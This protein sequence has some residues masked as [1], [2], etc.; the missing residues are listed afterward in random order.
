MS[1]LRVVLLLVGA[2]IITALIIWEKR[3]QRSPNAFRNAATQ[4]D[5]ADESV[6]ATRNRIEPRL[7]SPLPADPEPVAETEP[8]PVSSVPTAR[9]AAPESE[10][11]SQAWKQLDLEEEAMRLAEK[12]TDADTG[13]VTAPAQES[14]PQAAPPTELQATAAP[15]PAAEPQDAGH[16][17]MPEELVI[18]YIVAS[19]GR[20]IKGPEIQQAMKEAGLQFG[21]MNLFHYPV[22]SPEGQT[23]NLF[24]VADIREPGN[25]DPDR[26]AGMSTPG[27]VV[28]MQLPG[29][30]SGLDAFEKMLNVSQQLSDTLYCTLK[31]ERK[32]DL[33]RTEIENIKEQILKFN[34]KL[35]S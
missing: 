9:P 8:D 33:G 24:S 18:L 7:A 3:K 31:D 20:D 32:H 12:Q 22:L 15:A 11:R 17:P 14:I 21:E 35:Y 27:L 19:N 29:P 25:F 28:F 16:P 10:S 4:D 13:T 26:L 2:I 6:A 23:H 34:L 5:V 30:L 1:S